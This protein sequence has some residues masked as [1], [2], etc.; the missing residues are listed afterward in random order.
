[1]PDVALGSPLA[2]FLDGGTRTLQIDGRSAVLQEVPFVEMVN[3]RGNG[4]DALFAQAVQQAT[5]LALPL[6]ANTA[7]LGA[8][9]QWLWLGPDEWL[10]KCRDWPA[11]E[12][13]DTLSAALLGMHSAVVDV[14]HG[15]TT[16]LLSGPGAGELL[17]RGCPLD[18]H[19]R[20]FSAG[21]V[22][23]THVAKAAATI[24]CVEPGTRFELTVRRS[25]ADYLV[26]WLCAA[27]E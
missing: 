1:M 15:N 19:P 9:R 17:A 21:S 4:Q 16:V 24:L 5:G 11:T 27:G 2:A 12:A 10:L 23:Q 6:R 18:L 13:M 25:F 7:S 8:Q 26:R 20:V 3:L 14:G 22:A